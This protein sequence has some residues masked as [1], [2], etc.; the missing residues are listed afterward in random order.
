MGEIPKVLGQCEMPSRATQ[1]L[2]C[3]LVFAALSCT[4]GDPVGSEPPVDPPVNPPAG[5]TIP[6]VVLPVINSLPVAEPNILLI[7]ADDM[8]LDAT[9]G[10]SEGFL[11]ANMPVLS[12]LQANG[13]TFEQFWT[14]PVCSPT[15]ATLLTGR[16]GHRTG[17]LGVTP[18]RENQIPLDEVSLHRLLTEQTGYASALIGK[19]H[20]SGVD[21]GGDNNPNMMGISHFSGYTAGG[22]APYWDIPLNTN[23]VT[24]TRSEYTTT[25][26]TDQAIDWIEGQTAPWFAWVAYTAPHTPFHLPT[27]GLHY[28]PSLSGTTE[29]IEA[30]P[31]AYYRAAL[32]ALDT[33]V[34]RLL[35]NVDMSRTIVIFLGDNGTPAQVAQNPFG[36]GTA[37]GTVYQGGAGTPLVIAG[38][39]V[40]R[41]GEREDALVN[42][43][44]LFAT[45]AE[46]SGAGGAVINDGFS[47]KNLL[48]NGTDTGREYNLTE[49]EADD[50]S[51]SG[52]AIRNTQFKLL[53]FLDGHREF[54]DLSA[55]PYEGTDLFLGVLSAAEQAALA[56]LEAV[57]A[58][59]R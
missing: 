53:T 46:I 6:S 58:E 37:K 57:A 25:L 3:G 28:T 27:K 21:N 2:C 56:D 49:I 45:V 41:A 33:E 40:L 17:V 24:E 5:D 11:K 7:I 47:L 31:D 15:R 26:F 35:N 8:G 1:L 34:G 4:S 19:W 13:V 9:P 18:A 48:A 43:A 54:Y 38:P 10:Y 16:Y 59:I 51:D 55:D 44:D 39:G 42:V 52:W 32:E 36:R 30:N 20:L 12:H 23:G 14:Y 50:A 22:S 29:D